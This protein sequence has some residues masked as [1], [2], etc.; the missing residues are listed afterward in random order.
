MKK[1]AIAL[2][3]VLLLA[4]CSKKPI[5]S[6][7]TDNPTI[8]VDKLFTHDGITVYRFKDADKSVYFSK[9]ATDISYM[10]S[11]GKSCTEVRQTLG[12]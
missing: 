11:C 3:S 1:L 8:Q 5:S 4:S 7:T 10:Q 2:A 9:P 6:E 12:N